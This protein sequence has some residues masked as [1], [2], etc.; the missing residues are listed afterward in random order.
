MMQRYVAHAEEKKKKEKF[1]EQ[2]QELQR[3]Q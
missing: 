1:K 2:P 3:L